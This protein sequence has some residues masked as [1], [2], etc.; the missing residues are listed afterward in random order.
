MNS[1][2][3]GTSIG[4]SSDKAD[5]ISISSRQGNS[6]R[7]AH[8]HDYAVHNR[9]TDIA[10]ATSDS[11][12]PSPTEADFPLDPFGT[13]I[14]KVHEGYHG[15]GASG[16][17]YMYDDPRRPYFCPNLS[18]SR[19]SWHYPGASAGSGSNYD[20]TSS[21]ST[22]DARKSTGHATQRNLAAG[23][24][25]ITSSSGFSKTG[26][27]G[28]SAPSSSYEDA[29]Y[30]LPFAHGTQHKN[31]SSFAS[32]AAVHSDVDSGKHPLP[33]NRPYTGPDRYVKT[34]LTYATNPPANRKG[35]RGGGSSGFVGISQSDRPLSFKSMAKG[36]EG[37]NRVALAANDGELLET[38]M[39]VYQSLFP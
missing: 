19:T 33:A 31:S 21:T 2:V 36:P 34:I 8:P 23:S 16:L 7:S 17:E 35:N 18:P 29:D 4:N 1:V 37:T 15:D 10:S 32:S 27:S 26:S 5:A 39:Y 9:R 20:S 25:G 28:P 6:D 24:S 22:S 13:Q 14:R 38:R 30:A 12:A 11:V 3:S